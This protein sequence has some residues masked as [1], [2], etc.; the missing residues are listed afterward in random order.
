MRILTCACS[1]FLVLPLISS[2]VLANPV[3]PVESTIESKTPENSQLANRDQELTADN[4]WNSSGDKNLDDIKFRLQDIRDRNF[5]PSRGVPG[6]TIANPFGFGA[7]RG[8]YS[9]LSY[10]VDT[11][12]GLDNENDG[13]ATLGFGVGFGNAQKYVG[14][15][16]SYSLASFGQNGRDFGSGGFNLKLHRKISDGWG[17]AAGWNSFLS[18]GDDNDLDDSL[19]LATTKIF[20]TRAN[21]NSAFSRVGATIGVGNGQFRTEDDILNDEGGVNVFGSLALRVARP[22]SFVTEWSGQDLGMG[23]SVSPFRTV[24]LTFNLSARD[25]AGAGDGARFVFGV[26]SAL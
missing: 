4:S 3:E 18:I 22:V 7:D 15:E 26:G 21:V 25:I 9:G 5:T 20:K 14:A 11:R 1:T 23:I 17:V 2:S 24:P 19:Y 13:D 16:L 10:Q 12:G 6:L 8:F